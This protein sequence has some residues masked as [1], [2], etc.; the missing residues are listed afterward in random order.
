MRN[1]KSLLI[2][3]TAILALPVAVAAQDWSGLYGGITLGYGLGDANHSFS[4]LA[5]SGNSS[6][7]GILI[8][9]F[10]GYAVQNGNTVWGGEIDLEM[11]SLEGSFVNTT[12]ATSQGVVQGNWQGS[13]R[14]VLGYA[15]ALGNK[16]TLYYAT[17]GWAVGDFDFLGGPSVPVPPGGGYNERL[18]GWTAGFG[19]DMELAP[20]TVMRA[21]YRYTDFGTANGALAPTFPGVTMPVDV[22]QH[23]LRVGIRFNF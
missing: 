22:T 18:N 19:M 8:G 2:T 13:L 20:N 4:N 11:S 12:G 5:P 15:G 23:A 17:A 21:E 16:P 7:D 3:T 1:L 6:P 14:G 9:G 10:M